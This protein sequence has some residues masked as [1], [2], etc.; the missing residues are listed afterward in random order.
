[1]EEIIKEDTPTVVTTLQDLKTHL[2]MSSAVSKGLATKIEG[3]EMKTSKGISFLETKNQLMLSYLM[4]LTYVMLRKTSGLSLA[5]EDAIK[6]LVEIRTVMERMRPIEKKLQYQIDKII[7]NASG[8]TEDPLRFRAN[9]MN[10]ASRDEE[11]EVEDETGKKKS[12]LYVPPKLTPMICDIDET[13]EDR[14]KV[15]LERAKKRALSGSIMSELRRE[16]DTAPEEIREGGHHAFKLDQKDEQKDLREYEEEFYKRVKITNKNRSLTRK[17]QTSTNL[18][19]IAQ[20]EDLRILY[21]MDARLDELAD[22]SA[23]KKMKKEKPKGKG[24]MKGKGGKG[25]KARKFKKKMK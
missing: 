9:P 14:K 20:F 1:M 25:G 2:D 23:S 10:L 7:R 4:N 6:R 22:A 16:F 13:E 5:G 11:G 24:K 3:S 15:L 19:N 17:P 12:A 8:K 18:S 21:D